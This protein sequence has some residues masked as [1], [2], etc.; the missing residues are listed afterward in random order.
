MVNIDGYKSEVGM[1]GKTYA[2]YGKTQANFDDFF[3]SA[4]K[5]MYVWHVLR[6]GGK[7]IGTRVGSVP[8]HV[9]MYP[10]DSTNVDYI[11]FDKIA[12]VIYVTFLSEPA[13]RNR[14]AG[15]TARGHGRE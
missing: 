14:F 1:S 10:V 5:G 9:E 15:R 4:S 3:Y 6:Q 12:G 13:S 2:Y 11:G 7:G 8:S